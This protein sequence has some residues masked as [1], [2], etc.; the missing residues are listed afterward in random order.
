MKQL[1]DRVKAQIAA[2]LPRLLDVGGVVCII[3]GTALIFN[4]LVSGAVALA[5]VLIAVG[6]ALLAV[7]YMSGGD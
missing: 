4:A 3:G 6:A 1:A 5:V 7:A 2:Q